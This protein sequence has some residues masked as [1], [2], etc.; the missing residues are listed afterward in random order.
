MILRK[1]SKVEHG[2][3]L[4]LLNPHTDLC[5]QVRP[6]S[7]TLPLHYI[8]PNDDI[9]NHQGKTR[10]DVI[11]MEYKCRGWPQP[12]SPAIIPSFPSHTTLVQPPAQPLPLISS[13]RLSRFHSGVFLR[14]T[15]LDPWVQLS[16]S[17]YTPHIILSSPEPLYKKCL[18]VC[19]IHWTTSPSRIE[20][21]LI[22]FIIL[23]PGIVPT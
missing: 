11:I 20:L 16:F 6:H 22:H 23:T 19:L 9:N 12:A 2:F 15:P 13:C 18:H 17:P 1:P 5:S 14:K 7:N 10:S 3:P 8:L 4:L 21:N